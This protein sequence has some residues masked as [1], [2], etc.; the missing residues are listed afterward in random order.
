[1]RVAAVVAF[2]L[3]MFSSAS[4]V[5]VSLASLTQG[6]PVEG[7]RVAAVYLN[8]ADQPFGARF[9]HRR[10]GMTLDL[11]QIES[12][13]QSY[14][15]VNSFPVSDQGEPH[16]QEH[17]LLGKGTVGR[18]YSGTLTMSLAAENA[19]TQ[20][21]RT[22]YHFDTVAGPDVFF[23]VY[24]TQLHA[25]LKP[26]YSDEEIRREVRNFGVTEN[27]NGTLRLEEK[28]SVYNE[29]VGSTS[30]PFH[31]FREANRLVYGAQHPLAFN[32]GGEPS[33]I[34][35]MK[36]EDIRRFHDAHY[37]LANMGS[38]VAFPK[39]V[40]IGDALRR[41]DAIFNA[42]E[43]HGKTRAAITMAQQP[44]PKPAAAGTIELVEYPQKN[45]QQPSPIAFLWPANRELTVVDRLLLE[46]FVDNIAGDATTNLYKKFIDSKTRT[47]NIGAR[48]VFGQVGDELG[49]PV[50]IAFMDVSAANLNEAKLAAI[51]QEVVDEIARIAAFADGSPELKEFND[52]ISSRVI[53]L[54]R[55]LSKFV[56]SPPGFG[57]RNTGSGWM[58]HLYL[59][60]QT[61][62]FRKPVTMKPELEQVRALLASGR[63]FWR[64]DLAKWKIT[65][66]V[67]F[68]AAAKPSPELLAR[69]DA[70]RVARGNAESARL[71][72]MYNVGDTQEAI[73]RYRAEYDAES[74]RI[75]AE[76]QKIPRPPFVKSPPMT[77]DD[78]LHFAQSKVGDVPM[79]ASTFENM[80]SAMT[81]LALRLDS[82]PSGDLR[83]L[84]LMPLLLT[85]VGVIENGR[86]VPYEEMSERLRKEILSLDAVFSTNPKTSRVEMTVRASGN[87]TAE[88]RRAI[89]WMQLVLLHPDW[90]P[91]NLPRIRD[92]VDQA[93]GALRNTTAGAEESWVQNPAT[94]YRMQSNPLWLATD[95]FLTRLHNALRLKWMLKDGTPAE[96]EAAAA[97]LDSIAGAGKNASRADLKK[98]ANASPPASIRLAS[99]ALKDLDLTLVEIPDDSLAADWASVCTMMRD[100]LRTPPADALAAL[101]RVR[102]EIPHVANA[103]MF[104]VGSTA[105]QKALASAIADVGRTLSPSALSPAGR[106][107][108]PS[109]VRQTTRLIDARLAQR[110]PAATAPVYVGLV[111]PNMKG[112]VIITSVPSVA[113]ADAGEREKQIDYLSS[114]LYAGAGAHGI[115]LKTIGAGLAYSNG[116]RGTVASGR[117]GYYAERT[118]ELPQTVR[119]VVH[120]LK[121]EK[122]DTGLADYAVAQLFREVRSDATYESRAEAMAADLA[123][124]QPPEQVRR[125]RESIL[126]LRAD[127]HLGETLFDRK[128]VVNGRIL[129]GYNVKGKD[130]PGAVYFT[131]GPDK[132]LDAF[133]TY[134]HEVE[135]DA[136]LYKLYPRDY[137][138]E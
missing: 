33:G 107:E 4:A 24:R 98:L 50:L 52:R 105:T 67:P 134:L 62:E 128:D 69:E 29:M 103:R 78:S 55:D 83:W 125:F 16:T 12:V 20:Q 45:D 137:W 1:M 123:D 32:S 64:D 47:V 74:A 44:E 73:R 86:P 28:G 39:S 27:A 17:L 72:K 81:G 15:W 82:V 25:L 68:A 79:V 71:A 56:N 104:V 8:D 43:P 34:R 118:P 92:V 30:S 108:S 87:D 138:M 131:I 5:E 127:P 9:V 41:F 37:Y 90:R 91:E 119:F 53:E 101:D 99:D 31:M 3:M 10:T 75:E 58:D 84:S 106:A 13:P 38:I 63:N 61:P 116:L 7:F 70:E 89:E 88:A 66:V 80:T 23:D 100:A 135:G 65:G 26:N 130:V 109:Y 110:E 122:R 2:L 76:A 133:D 126:Q 46:L 93:L 97:W 114:R 19:F 113:Y 94:A 136:K 48:S 129:P 11:L 111:T 54:H 51:R 18:A 77:M 102:Q 57:F 120:E 42:L 95:S 124:G 59:L 36:P 132:Q 112:G 21:W 115:F 14:T 6:Q 60:E 49:S 35:T 117:Y 85:R 121:N 96:R 22:S 40:S